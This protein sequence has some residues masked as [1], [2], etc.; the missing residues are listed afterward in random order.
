MVN[1][2]CSLLFVKLRCGLYVDYS[3]SVVG[4]ICAVWQEYLFRGVSNDVKCMCVSVP[5]HIADCSELILGIL[6]T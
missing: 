3:S 1:R 6:L 2:S 4:H 5:S